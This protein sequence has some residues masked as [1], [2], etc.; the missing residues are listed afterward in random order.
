M[1][2]RCVVPAKMSE[3]SQSIEIRRVSQSGRPIR[4]G[5]TLIAAAVTILLSACNGSSSNP[6]GAGQSQMLIWDSGAW[7]DNNWN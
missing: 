3:L 2:P 1:N 6:T 4:F 7:D 5:L